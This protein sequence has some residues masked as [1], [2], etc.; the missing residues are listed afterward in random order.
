MQ[1]LRFD[2]RFAMEF[3]SSTIFYLQAIRESVIW[4]IRDISCIEME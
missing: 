2:I 3:C 1:N 4:P